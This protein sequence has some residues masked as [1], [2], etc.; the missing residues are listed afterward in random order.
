M[1]M[2][3][4]VNKLIELKNQYPENRI[5]IAAEPE[6]AL[7]VVKGYDYKKAG[8]YSF[9]DGAILKEAER[10]AIKHGNDAVVIIVNKAILKLEV[11]APSVLTPNGCLL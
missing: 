6:V 10:L 11:W 3:E 5:I 2:S 7:N 8:S 9:D 4:V 1:E